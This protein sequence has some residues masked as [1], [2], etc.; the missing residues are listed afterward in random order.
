MDCFRTF[1]LYFCL[2][3]CSIRTSNAVDSISP[4][5]AIKDGET[6]I[7]S[8]Q[9]YE[10]GFFTPG[11]SSGR[12]LGIWFKKISTGTVVWVANRETP[13]PDDKGVLNFTT[14][15]ILLLLNSSNG[16]IWSSNK[17]S[18][19]KN[20]IAQLLDSG[21]FVVKNGN[22]PNPENYLWQS[23]DFPGDTNLPGMKLGR[24]LVT[25]LDWTI[26][27]WKSL[28]DPARGDYTFGIDPNGYPQLLYKK[29][30]TIKFRAG[31]WNG[32]RFTGAS[33]LRPNPVYEYEFVLNEKE[34]YYNIH[35]LNNSVMSRLVVNASGI[36][37]RLTWID[38]THSWA[39]YFAVGED[40]CDNYNLCGA[41]AICNINKS[42]MCACLEGF[43]PKSVRDWSFQ[44]WSSGC[45]RK[46]ALACNRGEGFVK[47]TGKKMPDTS[48][49]WFDRRMS[50]KECEEMCLKNC[51]CVAY[52]NTDITGG[53]NG[54]LL[55][56]SDLIDLREFIDTGQDL[57]VRMS[58][59]YLDGIKRRKESRRQKRIGIIVCSTILGMGV[60]AL[61]WI[62]YVRKRKLEIQDDFSSNNKLG[63]GGFGPVYKGTF[64]DGQEIAVKR[65]S[66]SSCQGLEEFKNE[67]VLIAKLQHRNL[68]KLL[69]CC[70][71]GDERMLIY[72][73]MP[74]KSL[75]FFIFD[76]SRSKLL[77]WN[78]RINIIDGIA[79]G[80]L[81]LHQDSRLRIIHR[82]LKAS[83]VL[84]DKDMNPKISD[85]GM[86]RI[87]GGDQTEANTNRVVGTFGYMAPEYAV[88]GL[89]SVKSDIFSFGVLVLEIVSGSKNRGFHSHDHLHNLVG[90][91]WRLW[92]EER[93]LELMDNMLGESATLSEIIRCI[94]VGLLCVQQRPEDRPNMSTVVLMLGGESS[95][96]QP[97]QP[98]FFTER[99]VPEAESSSSYYKST[100]TNEITFTELNP[101]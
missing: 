21:N 28:N 27:S 25:G 8:G 56:F 11:S 14:Q 59:S 4:G 91:A 7:S 94:H 75:D 2:L 31:S 20:P 60:L 100:S 65:L 80:L 46:I 97:K 77:D 30:N 6:I 1:F 99:N 67:V 43:E 42:P 23:F 17:T 54:C 55:W 24:N 90:H 64:F 3:F 83:N 39:T 53:G 81:Y 70:I 40:Q 45:L 73:Y 13:L 82:D 16:V 48:G 18:T 33:R 74:N 5:Q 86:A 98:G 62:L 47:H 57:Y 35:L 52:A 85:F 19:V 63:Q 84:L 88:D 50:L 79:R 15:G 76:Q 26:S 36:T 38:Q 12:Y 101:R 34:V 92:M 58:A 37:E 69:G 29:G 61:G 89:F 41:N 96:P 78:K 10:L 66:M 95:L 93:P 22:E 71:E 9:T 32:I 72:E 51:S 87:F 44:D 49:S 68:V